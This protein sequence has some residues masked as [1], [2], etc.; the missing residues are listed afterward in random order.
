M[1]KKLILTI[2]LLSFG[3]FSV[4]AAPI[5]FDADGSGGDYTPVRITEL[6]GEATSSYFTA[7]NFGGDSTLGNGDTFTEDFILGIGSGFFD[8]ND[9]ATN[10]KVSDYPDEAG[11]FNPSLW[12]TISLTG[13]VFNYNDGGTPTTVSDVN[14]TILDDTF[15]L[16]FDPG[17]AGVSVYYNADY[18]NNADFNLGVFDV[19]DGGSDLFQNVNGTLTS[20][21]G[22]SLIENTLAANV[23]YVDN[24]GVMGADISTLP[25]EDVLL[26]L[27]DSS[28]NLTGFFAESFKD[29]T[30]GD[31]VFTG[32]VNI[33]VEDNGTDIEFQPVPEPS[34]I[35][36]LGSGLL[37]LA[38]V[39][40]K[41]RK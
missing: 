31:E 22:I 30:T 27:A 25:Y 15:E 12:A 21:V 8:D 39:G 40:R 14:T 4:N 38:Y 9:P 7:V 19:I 23:F 3:A 13:T 2:L 6:S 32:T 37:G 20:D 29:M 33:L 24:G 5:W 16:D 26:A 11:S 28:V 1:M 34:T 18:A 36:L 35:I 17:T 41:R 10:D